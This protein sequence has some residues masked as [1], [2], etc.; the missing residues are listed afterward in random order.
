[1][2]HDQIFKEKFKISILQAKNYYTFSREIVKKIIINFKN[3]FL[4]LTLTN[5]FFAI[6]ELQQTDIEY[7]P[8]NW[9]CS[10]PPL[11]FKKLTEFDCL[12]RIAAPKGVSLSSF[13]F[14]LSQVPH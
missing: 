4:S 6:K 7:H 2:F 9:Q 8:Q 14:I 12:Q 11:S 3:Y 13:I 1:M 10:L 5:F